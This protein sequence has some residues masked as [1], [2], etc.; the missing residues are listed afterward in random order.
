MKWVFSIYKTVHRLT[1]RWD[2]KNRLK[3]CKN[4]NKGK[5]LE[6]LWEKNENKIFI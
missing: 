2:L 5:N 4:R 1:A 3:K 6:I